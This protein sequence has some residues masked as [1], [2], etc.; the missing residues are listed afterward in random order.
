MRCLREWLAFEIAPWVYVPYREER[1]EAFRD[2]AEVGYMS[3]DAIWTSPRT[4]VAVALREARSQSM[5]SDIPHAL[6][7]LLR[8]QPHTER[9]LANLHPQRRLAVEFARASLRARGGRERG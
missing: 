5:A 6:A 4:L 7:E 3:R 9:G 2:L 1:E 8:W